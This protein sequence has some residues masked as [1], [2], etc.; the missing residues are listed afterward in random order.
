MLTL[1]SDISQSTWIM[2]FHLLFGFYLASVVN[3]Q[4]QLTIEGRLFERGTKIPIADT[5]VFILPHKLKATT[6][7]KG[8]FKFEQV[9]TGK[10]QWVV[11]LTGYQ[12]LEVDDEL[13]ESATNE[14]INLYLERISY[15]AF[16]TT[17]V[18]KV[19]KEDQ[20]VRTLKASVIAT[21]PGANGDPVKAVQNLPGVNR[22]SG[23]SS[24]VIIQGSSPQDTRY[25]I[26]DHEVPI[27]F[28]FGGLTSVITP[29]AVDRVDYFSAGYGSEYGRAMGG[30]VGLITRPPKKDRWQ[31]HAF[32]DTSKAGG[33][34]EG[35]IGEKGSLLIS[36]RYSYIGEVIK[37]LF[38][39]NDQFNLTVAPQFS[40]FTA[41]YHTKP[42]DQDEVKVLGIA[43]R[44]KLGFVL[45]EPVR[46][47]P[48]IRGNFSNETSFFRIVPQW[49]H[50]ISESKE[51][52]LSLAAGKDNL[53]VDV[54][55]QYFKLNNTSLSV[56]GHYKTKISEN[57][58]SK[59]GLDNRYNWGLVNIRLPQFVS[60]GGVNNPI[61]SSETLQADVTSKFN[62]IG[63]YWK[64]DIKIGESPLMISPAIRADYFSPTKEFLPAP[65]VGARYDFNDTW[66][67]YTSGGLYYQAPQ[68]QEVDRT[69][70]NPDI[71]SPR[72]WHTMIG[73]EKDFREGSRG[74]IVS[75][76]LFYKKFENLVVSSSDYTV[77]DGVIAAER[78]NNKGS[79]R[80]YGAEFLIRLEHEPWM[81]W[82]SY[83]Y[84]RSFRTNPGQPE[85]PFQ[86]DQTHNINLL[87]SYDFPRN[88]K[89]SSRTR[90]VTGNPTTPIIDAALDSD[91]DAYIP[92][93]GPYYSERLE[94]FFQMDLRADKKWV[95]DTWILWVYLDIQ[96][97]TNAKNAEA[98]RYSYDYRTKAN[99]TGLPV[100]PTLGVK[101]EF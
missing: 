41:I 64:N 29:E 28:H 49:T 101:G 96:N 19:K 21:L 60:G 66:N 93:R 36:G 5:N 11:N 63:G 10:M 80:A 38:K 13:K 40:D 69:F 27:V 18:G 72:A 31:G 85:Y 82:L 20:T 23:F 61:S 81:G 42:S 35:P 92:I 25:L 94:P 70:G 58:E 87:V 55:D 45:S 98:V 34:Y 26:D 99:I 7:S 39:D 76:N 89:L 54:G 52:Q 47:D 75:S 90:Y 50:K 2:I 100:F 48:A 1:P 68:P 16:E 59:L 3:A 32:M 12:K 97:I 53:S 91:N 95:Y 22:S 86:Y 44:D 24:Q 33:L 62:L 14:L 17:I 37:T 57:W 77:R 79:G 88:W 83:T 56:R 65:R 73:T 15:Q 6:D 84:S 67:A 71:K 4:A 46:S 30:Q 9:P 74:F 43:S 78:Y 8:R 51:Y